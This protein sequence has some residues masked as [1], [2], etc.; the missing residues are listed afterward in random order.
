VLKNV[1]FFVRGVDQVLKFKYKQMPR[2][3][4]TDFGHSFMIIFRVLCGEWIESMWD[5]VLVSGWI[6]IPFFLAT[7]IIGNLVVLNLFLALLLSSFGASNLSSP[8]ADA[9]TNKLAE[10]F[11][12]IARFSRWTKGLVRKTL[13]FIYKIL[14]CWRGKNQISDQVPTTIQG[15]TLEGIQVDAGGGGGLNENQAEL[16]EKPLLDTESVGVGIALQGI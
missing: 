5:C 6:C 1:F 8:T 15:Q 7:V 9:E 14:T 10:A 12:R 3:N 16:R 13:R 2:W 4:F 11:N